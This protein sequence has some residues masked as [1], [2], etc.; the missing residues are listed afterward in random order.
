MRIAKI[1][2]VFM[3]LAMTGFVF[4]AGCEEEH[5]PDTPYGV[6]DFTYKG[7]SYHFEN[8]SDYMEAVH[9]GESDSGYYYSFDFGSTNDSNRIGI[10]YQPYSAENSDIPR[11]GTHTIDILEL[12]IDG[13]SIGTYNNKGTITITRWYSHAGESDAEYCR[14]ICEGSFSGTIVG[15]DGSES[16]IEGT[17]EGTIFDE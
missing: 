8:D 15:S 7:K 10:M 11:I 13:V 14:S 5:T 12:F 16:P 4:F 9:Y 6:C 1:R 17:F 3:C 2:I